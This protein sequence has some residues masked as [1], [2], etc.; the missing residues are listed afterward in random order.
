MLFK[1]GDPVI[2]VSNYSGR[3]N[4]SRRIPGVVTKVARKWVTVTPDE[5]AW[6]Y[7]IEQGTGYG[8]PDRAGFSASFRGWTPEAL[9]DRDRYEE[10]FFEFREK[11]CKLGFG[12][13]KDHVTT[14]QLARVI[15]ILNGELD[16]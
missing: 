1:V 10:L 11:H 6:E 13:F 5:K 4:G 3:A 14:D 16:G 8:K 12:G 7:Q 2:I 9:A 15:N